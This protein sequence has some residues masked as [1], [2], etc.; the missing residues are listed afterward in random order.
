[1]GFGNS[2]FSVG[3]LPSR[4]TLVSFCRTFRPGIMKV[5]ASA[6]MN[7]G[8]GTQTTFKLPEPEACSPKH[9]RSSCSSARQGASKMQCASSVQGPSWRMFVCTAYPMPKRASGP[10]ELHLKLGIAIPRPRAPADREF[11][12]G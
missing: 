3:T 8:P 7:A 9:M 6:V 10:H 2:P 5:L 1:M 11:V 12:S 4:L